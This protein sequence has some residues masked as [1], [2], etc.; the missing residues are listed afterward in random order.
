MRWLKRIISVSLLFCLLLPLLIGE[1]GG[2]G[3]NPLSVV[4]VENLK[5]VKI[6][7]LEKYLFYNL[8]WSK[9]GDGI[10]ISFTVNTTVYNFLKNAYYN[11]TQ[12]KC[13]IIKEY[14][15]DDYPNATCNQ[16][17]NKLNN[18]VHNGWKLYQKGLDK[19]Y[20][21]KTGKNIKINLP[22]ISNFD[23]IQIGDNTMIYEY[24]DENTVMYNGTWFNINVTLF[25][26]LNESWDNTV[27]EIFVYN[28]PT[29]K[30]G[31]NVTNYT[32]THKFK[33]YIESTDEIFK[34]HDL[35]YIYTEHTSNP[36]L[37]STK[38]KE[39]HNLDFS[40]ICKIP[41]S[42]CSPETP[43]QNLTCNLTGF[44][45]NC[46]FSDITYDG[47]K[48]Y[49]NVT[50]LAEYDNTSEKILIDP[51]INITNI[52]S[53]DSTD[54]NITSEDGGFSH[55]TLNDTRLVV[56]IPFD[57]NTTLAYDWVGSADGVYG[58]E[59]TYTNSGITGGAIDLDGT[60]DYVD[61][62]NGFNMSLWGEITVSVWVKHDTG[63][64]AAT[65]DIVSWWW[66]RGAAPWD[67]E[68]WVLTHHSNDQYFWQISG[69]DSVT[70]GTVSVNWTHVVGTYNGSHMVLYVDG[71]SVDSAGG[72][73]GN[74]P[75]VS[76]VE[77][78]VIGSQYTQ[79]PAIIS[80]NHFEGLIDEVMIWNR[81]LT[82]TEVSN[83]Y[84]NQS[85][86][87]K[88]PA[89]QSFPN[90]NISQNGSYNRVNVTV[91]TTQNAGSSMK[92]RIAEYDG[93]VF[94]NNTAW[95]SITSGNNQ[96]I[97][98]NISTSTDNITLQFNYSTDSNNFF[99]PILSGDIVIE[100]WQTPAAAASNTCSCPSIN[101][102][103]NISMSDNCN[104][105]ATC[106]IGSGV[107]NIT[108]SGGS[109]NIT[110]LINCS[111]MTFPPNGSAPYI[112]SGGEIRLNG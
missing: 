19:G 38:K 67:S 31:A 5:L 41:N 99:S 45:A 71:S 49:F 55:I 85:Y 11:P 51:V 78:I 84:S 52:T 8:T 105:T 64:E 86:R 26:W 109:L 74:L 39:K 110:A 15:A 108:G 91:N 36:G 9:S 21:N 61:A 98:F 101:V 65:N 62:Y 77:S 42:S 104:I 7:A 35:Y 94:Q 73:S 33:Y 75:D 28:Q 2:S 22:S 34:F 40:D 25:M 89:N 56:Y 27:D 80:G 23:R 13:D 30:F 29:M 60:D 68:G 95:E 44:H 3:N 112:D 53:Y 10:N 82:S 32:G 12:Q 4:H 57:V 79:D 50:F 16:I 111:Y 90:I 6:S 14:I 92:L 37:I 54:N 46:S 70:G 1:G 81:S 107:L 88:T 66:F 103:W 76:Y 24:Q 100:S 93:N 106:N 97:S 20:I 58:N 72:L 102:N 63:A 47:N 48:Y 83:L 69:K 18:L 87:F 96:V 59:A 17:S 43:S